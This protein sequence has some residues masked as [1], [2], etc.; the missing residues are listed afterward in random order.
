M[1]QVGVLRATSTGVSR[2]CQVMLASCMAIDSRPDHTVGGEDSYQYRSTSRPGI[3]SSRSSLHAWMKLHRSRTA[4][5]PP[6][7]YYP[8]ET[9]CFAT[10]TRQVCLKAKSDQSYSIL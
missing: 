3:Q 5:G 8:V 6:S 2:F 9:R 10:S 7:S 1:T 4:T